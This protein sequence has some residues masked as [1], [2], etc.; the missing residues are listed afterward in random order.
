MYLHFINTYIF[1]F[2]GGGATASRGPGS[3]YSRDFLITHNDAPQPVGFHRTSDRLVAVT[4]TWQHTTY[5]HPCPRWDSNPQSQQASGRRPT[6]STA[7]SVGPSLYIF[8][9]LKIKEG[10]IWR[11]DI[12]ENKIE[13]VLSL[14]IIHGAQPSARL[15]NC[16]NGKSTMRSL[17][18]R[19][20][21]S[22]LHRNVFMAN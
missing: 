20:Y 7:W 3:P 11:R 10:A 16:C 2:G 14:Y 21:M 15:N 22:L 18:C 8:S 12:W 9:E 5:K 1:F 4:S 17:L 6:P 13:K 19:S